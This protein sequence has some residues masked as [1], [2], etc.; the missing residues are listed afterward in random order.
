MKIALVG[1][2]DGP[3]ILLKSLVREDVRPVCIGLQK[4]VSDDLQSEYGQYMETTFFFTGFDESILLEYLKDYDIDLL[5]NCFCNFKFVKLLARYE[6]LNVHLAP[7]PKYRGRHPLHW[8]L[9]NGESEFG[10]TI[11]RMD[12]TFDSGP[13]LWQKRV[14]VVTGM[15]VAALRQ[16]LMETVE[17]GFGK[18]LA[19][20]LAGRVEPQANENCYSSYA[21]RRYPKDSRLT[22]WQDAALIFRKVMALR[23]E[24][25]PAYLRIH[26]QHIPVFSAQLK[27]TAL[28]EKKEFATIHRIDTQGIEVLCTDGKIIGLYGFRPEKY[29]L[30]L[31]Q[32]IT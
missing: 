1:N 12:E 30:E 10:V 26:Q 20:F 28:Q 23:S 18:F 11:H 13:I 7:L 5:I 25:N 29:G 4:P 17:A 15:S 9:I 21:P 8:A 24:Q 27:D 32:K 3:L 31:K 16:T 2:N 19:D 14:P 6:I 22:E